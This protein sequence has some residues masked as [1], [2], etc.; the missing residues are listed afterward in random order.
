MTRRAVVVGAGI[1]GI[2]A[3]PELQRNGWTVTLVDRLEPGTGCSFGNAGI[4]ASMAAVPVGLPGFERQ[5][6]RMLL[7]PDS[8]LVL[9]WRA[10]PQ[11]IRR[12]ST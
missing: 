12:R 3:G 7:D 10:L 5:L 1:V 2:C 11:A 6:P 9:R 8:P 4:L